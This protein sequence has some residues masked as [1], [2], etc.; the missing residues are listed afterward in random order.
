MKISKDRV[1][2]YL[3]YSELRNIILRPALLET[4]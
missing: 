2:Q 3:E 1:D 4:S